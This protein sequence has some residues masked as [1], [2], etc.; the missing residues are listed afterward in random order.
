MSNNDAD[1]HIVGA[2]LSGTLLA[3]LLAKHHGL[4]IDLYE[5]RQDLR[6]YKLPAGRSIN[7]AL[8][9]RGIDALLSADL[10]TEVNKYVIPMYGRQLHNISGEQN[11]VGYSSDLSQAIY[12]ISR[13]KLNEIL[14]NAADATGLVNIYF[15]HKCTN[16]D[17]INQVL[18]FDSQTHVPYKLCIGADG[19]AS[20]VR[21]KSFDNNTISIEQLGH[22]YKELTIPPKNNDYQMLVNA[23]HIWPRGEYMLIALPNIDKSFTVTLFLPDNS[24]HSLYNFKTENDVLSF[25]M[26]KFPDVVPLIPDL[27]KQF[28]DNPIGKLATIRCKEWF[29]NRTVLLGDAAHAIVPFHGQGMNCAFEDALCFSNLYADYGK[30]ISNLIKQY[31]TKRIHNANAIADM[32]LENYIEMR[33]TVV[34]ERFKLKKQLSWQLQK[35]YP[36]EFIPRY[37]MVMFE[38]IPYNHVQ[39][40]GREQD[41][42]LNELTMGVDSLDEINF[43]LA[44]NLISKYTQKNTELEY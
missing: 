38:N 21:D 41:Y 11:M 7:L 30:D 10:M 27:V 42:I 3:I 19:F 29:V 18:E 5:S 44:K 34:C 1:V 2:G 33:D 15:E 12:S 16:N 31:V 8:A 9:K 36:Q 24:K 20:Q 25:F 4:R 40:L 39:Q 32:A 17:V 14:L 6:K 28:F 22:S 13:Q 23:L 26:D 35:L 43:D 37:N